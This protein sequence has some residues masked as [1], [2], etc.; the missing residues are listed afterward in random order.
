VKVKEEAIRNGRVE[1][2]W[3]SMVGRFERSVLSSSRCY[4]LSQVQTSFAPNW[5]VFPPQWFHFLR[6]VTTLH[7]I[8]LFQFPFEIE[9]KMIGRIHFSFLK[10]VD[11]K[12]WLL[13]FILLSAGSFFDNKVWEVE[14]MTLSL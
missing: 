12:C 9:I 6:K 5:P 4:S 8:I 14:P 13:V 1:V 2:R 10:W 11:D 7:F 3:Y